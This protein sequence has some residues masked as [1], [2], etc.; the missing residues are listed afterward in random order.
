MSTNISRRGLLGGAAAT[1]LARPASGI[2]ANPIRA[3]RT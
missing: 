1:L 3:T 2:G